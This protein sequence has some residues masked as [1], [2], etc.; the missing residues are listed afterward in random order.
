MKKTNPIFILLLSILLTLATIGIG[1][2]V[3]GT[4]LDHSKCSG[5]DG[6]VLT[7]PSEG[8]E[9]CC[10]LKDDGKVHCVTCNTD[11]NKCVKSTHKKIPDRLKTPIGGR[12]PSQ[13]APPKPLSPAERFRRP[14]LNPGNA[15]SK[16]AQPGAPATT[17]AQRARE[18]S[19]GSGSFAPRSQ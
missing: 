16:R 2:A 17:P 18:R 15:P 4:P 10:E 19:M 9:R 7:R 8:F 11:N 13:L 6:A 1:N 14:R 3:P 12:A 5:N